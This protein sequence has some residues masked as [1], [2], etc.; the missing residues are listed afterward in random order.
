MVKQKDPRHVPA[1]A[2]NV[3]LVTLVA[4]SLAIWGTG[5]GSSSSSSGTGGAHVGS[6]G[7]AASGGANGNGT[8]GAHVS[9]GG[10]T[11]S[12]GSPATSGGA[13]GSG[14]AVSTG[15]TAGAVGAGGH[16]GSAS[17]GAPGSGGKAGGAG[18]GVA[19]GGAGGGVNKA[20]DA[21]CTAACAMQTGLD[22]ADPTCHDTCVG[23]AEDTPSPQYN[24]KAQYQAM[25]NC[26]SKLAP[27]KWQC[28]D[29]SEPE[30][31]VGQCT[32]VVCAWACC[33]T[34]LYAN[35]LFDRCG[36]PNGGCP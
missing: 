31:V 6:T 29:C 35:S 17:G 9:T 25:L 20:L 21:A 33:E 32:T 23:K 10:T 4:V 13:T 7:G 34:D 14:G 5:C 1:P 3:C 18:G 30:P 22:C 11:S 28:S 16:A 19:M 27:A 2:R 26:T 24:C 36:G 15:G 12:G 8:G